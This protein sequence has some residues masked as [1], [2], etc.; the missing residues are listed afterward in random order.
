ED[1]TSQSSFSGH[2]GMK[3]AYFVNLSTITGMRVPKSLVNT[4]CCNAL[5]VGK[6]PTRLADNSEMANKLSV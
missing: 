6:G 1:A 4:L 3:C 5:F 2:M